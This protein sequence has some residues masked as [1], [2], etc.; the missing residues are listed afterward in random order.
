M[1]EQVV[2]EG[3]DIGVAGER[4]GSGN[5]ICVLS[6]CVYVGVICLAHQ[7]LCLWVN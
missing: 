3:D 4:K 5:Y 6:V 2:V 1:W 7:Y